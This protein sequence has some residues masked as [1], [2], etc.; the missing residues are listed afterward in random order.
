MESIEEKSVY[1]NNSPIKKFRMMHNSVGC[2]M[3][4]GY[5]QQTPQGPS[6]TCGQIDYVLGTPLSP[7]LYNVSVF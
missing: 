6:P 7:I 5:F 2:E 1:G 4:S 3:L